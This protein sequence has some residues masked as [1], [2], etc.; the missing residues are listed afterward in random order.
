MTAYPRM[1]PILA[2]IIRYHRP[3][4]ERYAGETCASPNA[5]CTEPE[6]GWR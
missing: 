3:F 5:D 1:L 6:D 4:F 2:R